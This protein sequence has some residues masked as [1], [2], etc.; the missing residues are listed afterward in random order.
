MGRSELA[1]QPVALLVAFAPAPRAPG[2][3]LQVFTPEWLVV[4]PRELQRLWKDTD[5]DMLQACLGRARGQPLSVP[6]PDALRASDFAVFVESV[7]IQL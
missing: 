2:E 1:R 3:R 7:L 6:L 5:P 4:P